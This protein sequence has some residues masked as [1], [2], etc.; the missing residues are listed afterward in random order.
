MPIK[1]DTI[2]EYTAGSGVTIDAALIKDGQLQGTA[3]LLADTISEKTAATGVTIDGALLKD[4][5][6]T[7]TEPLIAQEETAAAENPA[8]G[9]RKL[10]PHSAGDW[11][12]R[13]DAGYEHAL[14]W[15]TGQVAQLATN[16]VP[17]MWQHKNAAT[18]SQ[19][20]PLRIECGRDTLAA[21][22]C[23]ITFQAAFTSILEVFLVDKTAANAMYPSALATTGFTANGTSTDTFA[24][25]AIGV[26]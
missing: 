7:L 3:P 24:W 2:S 4:G 10:Y 1:T 11:L 12:D 20:G 17:G 6:A 16:P 23:A 14:A 25:L 21:G 8:A 22:T 5:G 9:Y 13:D 15:A 18:G 19:Y 26:D